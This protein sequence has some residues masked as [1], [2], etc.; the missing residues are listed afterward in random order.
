[1]DASFFVY[2]V[3]VNGNLA[4]ELSAVDIYPMGVYYE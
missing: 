3:V 2:G 4:V 1:M